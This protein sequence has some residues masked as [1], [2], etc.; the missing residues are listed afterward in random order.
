ML[1]SIF[2]GLEIDARADAV[3]DRDGVHAYETLQA[4]IHWWGRYLSDT[5]VAP[6]A[7]VS[8]E[9][10]YS[11]D[12]IAALLAVAHH[13]AV[14]VPIS[15][16]SR[17]H[18]EEFLATAC[19]QWRLNPD[20]ASI[21]RS[22]GNR[23]HPLYEELTRRGAP[24]LVLFTS[25]STGRSKA[26][27]HDL[28]RLCGKFLVRRHRYRTLAFLNADHIGGIN[29]LFYTI[30]NGGALVLPQR[31]NPA[32][33]CELIDRYGV[34][35]LP[36]SPTFL[37]LLLLA[38]DPERH[39]LSSLQL[40]TYGT[41]PMPESTLQQLRRLLP[42]V[43]LQQTYGLT[44]V[45][46]LRSRSREDGSLWVRIGGDG[47]DVQVR[48]GRLWVKAD[49]AM[50]G[51]LNA[52]NPFAPDGYLD[53]GDEVEVDGEWFKILGRKSEVVNVGGSKVFP[54]E[55][56]DIILQIPGVDDVLVRGEAHPLTGQIVVAVVKLHQVEALADFKSRLRQFCGSRLPSFKVPARVLLTDKALH[57]RRFKKQRLAV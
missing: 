42:Q 26:A 54:A 23:S 16:D 56:E 13:P 18:A 8:I 30:S 57:G 52:P 11:L 15:S 10:D 7:V 55:V 19:V 34:Q 17:T 43:R 20:T 46:I 24:G 45:G 1:D 28:S 40:V 33:I 51:Y 41:E 27:V 48:D 12:C 35:L 32:Y 22:N 6:H 4:R 3:V 44:E 36:T 37:K 29:T 31:R 47:F 50:L 2:R 39:Q 25:G 38:F 53:T 21:V 9:S 5:G 49:S 14:A